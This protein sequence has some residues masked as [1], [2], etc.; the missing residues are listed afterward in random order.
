MDSNETLKTLLTL[1]TRTI[2]G[3]ASADDAQAL[4]QAVLD[5]DGW[6]RA[7]GFAPADWPGANRL[8]FS[9]GDYTFQMSNVVKRSPNKGSDGLGA[10]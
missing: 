8:R 1:A 10:L 3:D 6:L 2:N 7:G 9:A 4:A 5:L